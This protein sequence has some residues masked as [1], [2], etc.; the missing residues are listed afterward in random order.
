MNLFKAIMSKA[1][2]ILHQLVDEENFYT[3]Q[4][5]VVFTREGQILMPKEDE[6]RTLV[7]SEAHDS[8]L[9]GHFGQAKTLEKGAKTLAMEGISARCQR[10]RGILSSMPTHETFHY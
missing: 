6:L 1:M 7:I 8:P 4:D 10:L 3:L 2:L 9:G 5:G